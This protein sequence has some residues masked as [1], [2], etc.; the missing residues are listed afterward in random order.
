MKKVPMTTLHTTLQPTNDDESVPSSQCCGFFYTIPN[1][2]LVHSW[3]TL[4]TSVA[5]DRKKSKTRD[6]RPRP[7]LGPKTRDQ[8]QDQI[9]TFLFHQI[10]HKKNIFFQ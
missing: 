9:K 7:R 3:K 6:S 8:D 4:N 5:Q 1:Y 10:F 2:F